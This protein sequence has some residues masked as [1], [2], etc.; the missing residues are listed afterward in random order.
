VAARCREHRG[1]RVST[2]EDLGYEAVAGIDTRVLQRQLSAREGREVRVLGLDASAQHTG[3]RDGVCVLSDIARGK[4][5]A[6]LPSRTTAML[7]AYC[8]GLRPPQRA[9]LEGVAIDRGAAE[10][11]GAR[12]KV[13]RAAI[14]VDRVHVMKHLPAQRQDAR[15]AAPRQLPQAM[16][17]ALQGWRWRRVR[18]DA[19]LDAE[20]RQ[21]RQRAF[22]IWPE[23]ARLHGLKEECRAF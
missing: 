4:V 13:P 23:L 14:V 5:I 10:A 9:A 8:A 12:R 16:R 7:A 2:V 15:R 1:P 21:Q 18:H 6:V 17:D 3:H 19:D 22:A 20:A 11:D